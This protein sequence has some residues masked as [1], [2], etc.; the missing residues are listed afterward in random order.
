VHT[1]ESGHEVSV[2]AMAQ[3]YADAGYDAMFLTNH[4]S[5]AILPAPRLDTAIPVYP[6]AEIT[7]RLWKG[8]CIDVL[9][10]GI[11]RLPTVEGPQ[12]I[13]PDLRALL[14]D[15][16]AQGG[17]AVLAH[18]KQIV[19]ES[20][21]R[22]GYAGEDTGLAHANEIARNPDALRGYAFDGVEW[23]NGQYGF[24]DSPGFEWVVWRDV[25]A[26]VR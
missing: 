8:L 7:V 14:A 13:A 23:Y 4:G 12:C 11:R 19:S 24:A 21:D 17:L 6:G 2:E 20:P 10:L 9:A 5:C 15:I 3:A 18:P 1:G 25:R 16:H 26:W 22:T